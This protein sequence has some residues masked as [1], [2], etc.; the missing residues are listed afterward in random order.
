LFPAL[1]WIF[2]NRFLPN[3]IHL[4]WQGTFALPDSQGHLGVRLH[5]A[6][7]KADQ[8]PLL[9]LDLSAT[10]LGEDKSLAA[11]WK[12]FD[13]AHEFIVRGFSELTSDKIQKD[14]W[15]RHDESQER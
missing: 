11:V 13:L 12:W 1:S 8:H 14:I 9:V 7:R 5:Q 2:E 10:G 6:A 15:K 3:P 4:G